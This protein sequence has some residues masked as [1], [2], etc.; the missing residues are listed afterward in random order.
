MARYQT[1]Y[2]ALYRTLYIIAFAYFS[3]APLHLLIVISHFALCITFAHYLCALSLR[4]KQEKI[5]S[6]YSYLKS[7]RVGSGI[8]INTRYQHRD[9]A[10]IL[11][12]KILTRIGSWRAGN[13]ARRGQSSH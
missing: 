6:I 13:P 11:D 5:L 3:F 7:C 10:R 2:R 8:R 12:T 4:G 1:P 9:P